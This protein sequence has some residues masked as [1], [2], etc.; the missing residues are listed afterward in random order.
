MH[1]SNGVQGIPTDAEQRM[2]RRIQER[3]GRRLRFLRFEWAD[4]RLVVRGTAP[5]YY[6][7]QLAQAAVLEAIAEAGGRP[8]VF[9]VQV[10]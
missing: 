10:V 1:D 6:L 5:S 2:E 4:G 8:P 7:K 3:T 9:D